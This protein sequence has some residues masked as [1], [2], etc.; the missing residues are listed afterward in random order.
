MPFLLLIWN[1]K[2]W[3]TIIILLFLHL[4][5]LA[6]V[7][8]L[9]NKIKKS[10]TQCEQ[11]VDAV[12]GKLIDMYV[13]QAQQLNKV[14]LNLAAKEIEIN[15]HFET[16][17]DEK[18]RIKTNIVYRNVCSDVAGRSLLNDEIKSV[19]TTITSQLNSAIAKAQ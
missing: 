4:A 19:N 14:S 9:A 3:A 17:R 15:E 10:N 16:V 7:N 6:H 13:K 11:R 8:Y 12:K 1:N 18:E 2:R 5:Q